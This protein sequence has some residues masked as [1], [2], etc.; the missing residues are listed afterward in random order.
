M[1]FG[2]ASYHGGGARQARAGYNDVSELFVRTTFLLAWVA[3]VGCTGSQDNLKSSDVLLDFGG[4][5]D[6][7]GHQLCYAAPR[8]V[9]VAWA[10][11]VGEQSAIWMNASDDGGL[12]WWPAPVQVSHGEG[13]ATEPAI[14]CVNRS[15]YVAWE[16][17]RDG[18]IEAHNIYFNRSL[19]GGQTWNALDA[20]LDDDS[21]GLTMSVG[22][23]LAAAG[24]QVHATWYDGREGAYDIHVASSVDQ[25][26]TFAAPIRMDSDAPGSAYSSN[27]HLV[28]DGMTHV[29]AV[30]EDSRNGL[31]DI[32]FAMSSDAGRTYGR[33]RRLDVGDEA[34]SHDSFS[35]RLAAQDGQLYVVWHDERNGEGRDVLAQWSADH[36]ASWSDAPLR[37]DG[38]GAGFTDSLFP[39]VAF[40]SGFAHVVWQDARTA[41]YD[42]YYRRM[43]AGSLDRDEVRVDRDGAGYAQSLFPQLVTSEDTV[44]VAWEDRRN[45]SGEVGYNDIFYNYSDDAGETWGYKDL[46]LDNLEGGSKY[47]VDLSL[48]LY[49][50][51]LFGAWRDGRGGNADLYFHVLAV[52]DEAAYVERAP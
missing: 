49:R 17:T 15:V 20:R 13:A 47:S 28:I 48:A 6:V 36:G 35:P 22:P 7:T 10:E 52:G 45:D 24:S 16:D 19:D 34:G 11:S 8:Q 50:G 18:E 4:P 9:Y 43:N 41:A 42:I 39:Q 37:V 23:V 26:Q 3:L 2:L 30:W 32:Y 44:V 51:T 38:D 1:R 12:T 14:A 21:E 5:S 25:G 33:D 31:S 29:Y 46:R 27:P 40:G